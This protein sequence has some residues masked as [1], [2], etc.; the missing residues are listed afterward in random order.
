LYTEN[1]HIIIKGHSNYGLG[2][3][4]ID[5]AH[6]DS[7]LNSILYIDDDKIF[8][9]SSPWISVSVRGMI[10][11]QAYP[12]WWPIFKDGTSGIMPYDFGDSLGD[13][14]YNYYITYQGP[15]DPTY[16]K[17]ETVRNSARVRFPDS[18][19][20]A[21]Y[22]PLGLHPEP[23]NPDHLQYYITNPD[24]SFES[25]GR[26]LTF[27]D[28]QGYYGNN[29]CRTIAMTGSEKSRWNFNIQESGFYNVYAWWPASVTN[30]TR[31]IYKVYHSSGSSDIVVNQTINGNQWNKLGEFYFDADN[32]Y[33]I[34]LTNDSISGG[35][36]ADAI[37]I[38]HRDNP[39]I[40]DNIFDNS[41]CPKTHY[42]GKTIL[43]RKNLEFE[44]EK[45]RYK[46]MLYD[47]C[48]VGSYYLDTFHRGIMFYT[49]ASSNTRGIYL[50]L[51]AYWDGKSDHEIWEILQD[52][53]PLYDYYNFDKLPWEQQ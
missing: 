7:E 16:Y 15:G 28:I 13:P 46:R 41:Y 43:F 22:S 18:N 29:F 38:T 5:Y 49:V 51:N 26:W 33:S 20:P 1:A 52:F 11:G 6:K 24:K 10:M 53:Q 31:V 17:I 44:P 39:I 48:T 32:K 8:N 45:L 50:Y 21:W 42:G 35:A 34:E 30:S 12:N 14:P 27:T 40:Y 4:F 23:Y 47:A 25:I 2:G 37:K 9:Y 19:V 36:I 3:V